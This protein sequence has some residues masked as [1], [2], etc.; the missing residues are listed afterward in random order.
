[1]DLKPPYDHIA[2]FDEAQRAWNKEQTVKFMKQKKGQHNFE[3]S[4]PEFLISNYFQLFLQEIS[5]RQR[6]GL[7]KK[8]EAVKDM[9]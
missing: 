8:Q 7:S 6:N 1:M 4:E 2:I 3:Y 9:V 5:K